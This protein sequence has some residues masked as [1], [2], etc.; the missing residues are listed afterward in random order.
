MPVLLIAVLLPVPI[1]KLVKALEPPTTAPELKVIAPLLFAMLNPCGPLMV[2][3]NVMP[4]LLEVSVVKLP[5]P[6]V[7]ALL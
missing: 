6:N 2:P 4:P 3:P 5:A 7:T 1:N